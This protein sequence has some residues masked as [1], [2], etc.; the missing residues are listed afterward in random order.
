[1]QLLLPFAHA[2]PSRADPGLVSLT[3]CSVKQKTSPAEQH[4]PVVKSMMQCPVCIAS[5]N[6]YLT[7]Q[8]ALVVLP[9][10][11]ADP[12]LLRLRWNDGFFIPTPIYTLPR[13]HAPPIELA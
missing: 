13:S 5:A 6:L 8:P 10:V 4:V 11:H 12:G 2:L 7:L 1:M 9:S 3:L